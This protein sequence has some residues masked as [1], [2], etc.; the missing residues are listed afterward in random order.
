MKVE[1]SPAPL[2]RFKAI[3]FATVFKEE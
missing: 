1:R 2:K 3:A